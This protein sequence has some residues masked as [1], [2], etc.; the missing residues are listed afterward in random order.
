MNLKEI[1]KKRRTAKSYNDSKIPSEKWEEIVEFVHHAPTSMNWQTWKAV[2]VDRD[3]ELM[4]QLTQN[5]LT[6]NNNVIHEA[7]KLMIFIAPKQSKFDQGDFGYKR[8]SNN[9]HLGS[10][11]TENHLRPE[12]FDTEVV[13]KAQAGVEAGVLSWVPS[14][15]EWGKRQAYIAVGFAVISAASLGVDTTI[16]EGLSLDNLNEKLVQNGY[17]SEDETSVIAVAFGYRKSD[18]AINPTNRDSK[19]EK[20]IKAK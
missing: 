9:M 19:E 4:S 3:S 6:F 13:K 5:E 20:F 12:D 1:T 7:D 2:I 11:R 10:L 16:M 17:I 14:L 8:V 18:S 15:E